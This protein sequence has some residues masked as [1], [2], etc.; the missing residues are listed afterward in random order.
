MEDAGKGEKGEK[1]FSPLQIDP[2]WYVQYTVTTPLVSL[3]ADRM[4]L[5]R[6]SQ[7]FLSTHQD[8]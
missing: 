6:C 8:R 3:T 4:Q 1:E 5:P 2:K 7:G